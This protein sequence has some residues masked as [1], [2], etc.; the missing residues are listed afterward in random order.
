MRNSVWHHALV[1][2]GYNTL[3]IETLYMKP[4]MS[5]T[6]TST[7]NIY[8]TD[9]FHYHYQHLNNISQNYCK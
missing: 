1:F 2:H 9:F 8:R 7:L 6:N 3:F 5:G 4:D